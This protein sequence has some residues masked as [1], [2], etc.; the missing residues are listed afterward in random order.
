MNPRDLPNLNFSREVFCQHD[1]AYLKLD[2]EASPEASRTKLK[3]LGAHADG[4]YCISVDN[5]SGFFEDDKKTQK[6]GADLEPYYEY[7]PK[8]RLELVIAKVGDIWYRCLFLS[9][10]ASGVQMFA[11]DY[12]VNFIVQKEDIWVK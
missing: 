3:V 7:I 6:Y 1:L 11:V 9:L 2:S 8:N 4:I 5:L 12:G 10:N